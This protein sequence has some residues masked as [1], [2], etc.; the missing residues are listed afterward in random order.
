MYMETYSY[1]HVCVTLHYL[2]AI[3]IV[4]NI[5]YVYKLVDWFIVKI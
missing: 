3:R 4:T 1:V 5:H 2:F